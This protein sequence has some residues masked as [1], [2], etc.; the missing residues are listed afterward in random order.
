[1]DLGPHAAFIWTAYGATALV[2]T[3]LIAEPCSKSGGR[4]GPLSG[5]RRKASAAGRHA[6]LTTARADGRRSCQTR[7][8]ESGLRHPA[9]YLWCS[10][11]A[12]R[13]RASIWRSV[14]FALGLD[15]PALPPASPFLPLQG[16]P[17][18][19]AA[20][21]GFST[22]DLATGEPTVVT[23]WASWC[24]PCVQ[25][26]PTLTQFKKTSK[27][28]LFGINY[29][30]EPANANRFLSRY[31]NPFDAI[32]ADQSGRVA[33]TGASTA[34]PRPMWSMDGA[35]SSISWSALRQP[36]LWPTRS[37]PPSNRPRLLPALR[38]AAK[39]NSPRTLK[40]IEIVVPLALWGRRP[41]SA[42]R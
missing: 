36:M 26:Q 39:P 32:G 1:M 23:V 19:T 20:I 40:P 38:P 42:A 8:A 13:G 41:V 14:A 35:R 28:R 16:A 18:S 11:V 5:S 9:H 21:P 6:R 34:C 29:K 25:E 22:A 24:G 37:C 33:S 2:V 31:G 30:D 4:S 15:R 12:V 27:F 3:A 17:A 7:M 10:R